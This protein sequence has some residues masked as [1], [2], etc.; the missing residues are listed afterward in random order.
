MSKAKKGTQ[1]TEDYRTPKREP[2][3]NQNEI[4]NNQEITEEDEGSNMQS[5]MYPSQ[6]ARGRMTPNKN[7]YQNT[8][9]K[10]QNSNSKNI[11]QSQEK[12]SKTKEMNP[13]QKSVNQNPD[14][15]MSTRSYLEQT[16]ASV[17]QEGM[18]ELAKNR[19]SNPLEFLGNFILE[20]A[21]NMDK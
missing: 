11:R 8:D 2:V 3:Q 20:R 15:V 18:I 4:S 6:K 12:Q 1:K 7:E 10:E 13:N 5:P 19:P 21:R 17:I 14:Q 16:V 9:Q